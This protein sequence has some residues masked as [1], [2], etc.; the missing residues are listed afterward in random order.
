MP[1][2]KVL[3]AVVILTVA[4][5]GGCT[6]VPGKITFDP[7]LPLEQTTSVIFSDAIMVQQYNG[8]NVYQDWYPNNKTRKNTVALPAG[9]TE[10]VLNIRATFNLG[11]N[12]YYTLTGENLPLKYNFEA[13]QTYN[14]NVVLYYDS[15]SAV[16]RFFGGGKRVIRLGIW[17][18]TTLGTREEALVLWDL[19]E[20]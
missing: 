14:I 2:K 5:L 16:E 20:I 18:G 4:L 7:Y 10:I 8:I 19:K 6:T 11:N 9:E 3:L 1:Q 17:S 15:E 13:G 12:Y